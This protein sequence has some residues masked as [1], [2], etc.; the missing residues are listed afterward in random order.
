M[1][2]AFFV[3]G[4][5]FANWVPRIP[6]INDAIGLSTRSLGLA[7]LG[8]GLGALGG[9]ILAAPLIARVGCRG[10]TRATALALGGALVLPAL[11][12]TGLWLAA[13]PVVIGLIDAGMDVAMNA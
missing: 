11:G 9:S 7:L 6:E 3:N 8:V 4:A 12:S 10:V 5:T 1:A 2:V 13:A